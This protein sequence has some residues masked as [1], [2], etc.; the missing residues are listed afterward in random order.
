MKWITDRQ[1]EVEGGFRAH[2]RAGN[3]ATFRV[4]LEGNRWEVAEETI[5]RQYRAD[6]GGL[7]RDAHLSMLRPSGL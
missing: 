7:S 2:G 3:R 6:T 5:T 4:R 1:A